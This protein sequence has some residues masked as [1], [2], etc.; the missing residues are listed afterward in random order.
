MNGIPKTV[1]F[2]VLALPALSQTTTRVDVDSAGNQAAGENDTPSLSADGRYVAFDS[3]ASN[4]VAGDANGIL[5][6]FVRDRQ[7]GATERVS[8]SS[9]GAEANDLSYWPSISFDGRYVV[10][11]SWATNLVAGDTNGR[12]D[13]F[14]RDRLLGTTERVSLANSGFESNDES[15]T[16]T[17]S[18]DGR[19]VAFT[20]FASN[21]VAGDT[22][23]TYDVFVR[24]RLNG[25]TE[26]VSVDSSGVEGNGMSDFKPVISRDGSCVAFASVATNLVA[27]DT[28]GKEDIFLRNRQAGT[29]ERIS[30]STAGTQGNGSCLY[31][32]AISSDGRFVGLREQRVEPR[33]GRHEPHGRRLP[34]RPAA[35]DDRA[36]EPHGGRNAGEHGCR[37][38]VDVRRRPV[39][40]LLQPLDEPRRRRHE[41]LRR[42]LP[43]RSPGGGRRNGSASTRPARSR[44]ST[45][46]WSLRS[47]TTGA[48]SRSL[49][50][51][52]TSSSTTRTTAAT[53]S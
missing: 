10:F 32:S 7:T 48:T 33:C 11:Q 34:A 29:T 46:S 26:R 12:T 19:F 20:S 52:R 51:P 16:A 31:E 21:L 40:L 28:N 41:R 37:P 4:L 38:A 1:V 45:P 35:R 25:T 5:D 49:P 27:A 47:R 24:D 9:G 18:G 23:G 44:T 43:S 6:V 15:Q 53:S 2:A 13:I 14:V 42:R 22:N 17:I 3:A 50:M 30:V 39:R 8:V 36:R